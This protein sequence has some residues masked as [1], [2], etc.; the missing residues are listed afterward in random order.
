MKMVRLS[1]ATI[2]VC[3]VAASVSA[4]ERR[5]FAGDKAHLIPRGWKYSRAQRFVRPG[6]PQQVS[7]LARPFPNCRYSGY[8][9]G[10]GAALR[11]RSFGPTLLR[12]EPRRIHEGTFGLDYKPPWSRVNLRWF[13]GVRYQDGE[14]QY[15][16]DK[17]NRPL[18][19]PFDLKP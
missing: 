1:L 4:E 8:Y 13:H 15:E 14:G 10:G 7:S 18:S 19:N 17:K 11:V 5:L 9:V 3:L 16:Q 6:C 12:G 2:A